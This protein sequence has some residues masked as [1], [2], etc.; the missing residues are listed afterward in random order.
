MTTTQE[1]KTF[2]EVFNAEERDIIQGCIERGQWNS[3]QTMLETGMPA[4]VS[5]PEKERAVQAK[6]DS[7]RIPLIPTGSVVR[8]E[9]QLKERDGYRIETPEQ[10]R[11]WQAKLDAERAGKPIE[12]STS[13]SEVS[14]TEATLLEDDLSEVELTREEIKTELTKR[15]IEFKPNLT[16]PELL[17]LLETQKTV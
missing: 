2:E 8:D 17:D 14:V 4:Y 7:I 1:P 5:T 16:K 15:G 11:E 6:I 10:E 13:I 9:L 3:I 12:A